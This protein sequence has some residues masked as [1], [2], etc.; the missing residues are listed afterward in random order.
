MAR[1]TKVSK[2]AFN[3]LSCQKQTLQ[4]PTAASVFSAVDVDCTEIMKH[5]LFAMVLVSLT[6]FGQAQPNPGNGNSVVSTYIYPSLTDPALTNFNDQHFVA[7]TTNASAR[8]NKLLLHLPGSGHEPWQATNFILTAA[9]LGYH[10]IS[11][12]YQNVPT[13]ATFCTINSDLDCFRSVT[14]EN[15]TG[16]FW[17]DDDTNATK[18]VTLT[19][20]ITNRVVKLLTFLS[21]NALAADQDWNQFLGPDGIQWSKVA[22]S[23]HSQGGS[24]AL[25]LTKMYAVDRAA[26]FSTV[27]WI[28]VPTN[29]RPTWFAASGATP[30]ER[31]YGFTHFEDFGGDNHEEQP[32]IWQDLGMT[33]FGPI[34]RVENYALPFAGSH[35]LTTLLRPGS[36]K[37]N[38]ELEYHP[39]VIIDRAI[40]TNATGG[41]TWVPVW[42]YMLTNVSAPL[43]AN[44]T[45]TTNSAGGRVLSW[46]GNS[47]FSS[48]FEHSRDLTNWLKLDLP[49]REVN[50]IMSL[51]I[52]PYLLDDE[53]RFFRL[54]RQALVT[55]PIPT[56][57]GFHTDMSFVH[58]GIAR[59]Y[60]LKIPSNWTAATNWPVMIVLPGHGQSITEFASRQAE[61]VG[62]ADSEGFIVVFAEAT[63]GID[64]YK[65]FA[66]D[67]PHLTQ[68]YVDDA[69]FLIA[70]ADQLKASGLNVNSNR[71]YLAGFSNGGSMTHY[72]ASRTNHPFAAF[73][74]MESGTASGTGFREPYDRLN[75]DAGI[76]VAAQVPLP[77]QPRPVLL[78]NMATSVPW[79]FEGRA[80]IRG[81]RENVARWTQANGFGGPVTNGLGII[82]PPSTPF[83]TTSN[84]TVVGTARPRVAY[85]DIRPDHNWPTNLIANGWNANDA[86]RFPYFTTQGTNSV[87]QR[88]PEW[89]RAIYPHSL[90]PDPAAPGKFVRVDSGTM[91]VEIWRTAPMNRTNE[92]IFVGLSDGG[93]QWPNAADKLPFNANVEVLRF[94]EAH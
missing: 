61:L 43:A 59:N 49:A 19:D 80:P 3:L 70:L 94:F 18:Q 29:D 38:G 75:P 52:P 78:M 26:L 48:Q 87:D 64:S 1:C 10:A 91:T 4:H 73:A 27:D 88:L 21:T 74:I 37:E 67:D 11:I 16:A 8:L 22:V 55:S 24:C 45:L 39:A 77:W 53:Q 7:L 28:R 36:T 2:L 90:S 76:N 40:P 42:S 68:P 54:S 79:V 23:G 51:E 85:D 47:G 62:L 32:T 31:L 84:W 69:A 34:L 66:F 71:L 83:N 17:A 57:A 25:M 56:A 89:V 20:S 65:W 41:V 63:A 92:V 12:K 33:A 93:H 86:L 14:E 44:L 15:I 58:G 82:G 60:F 6:T 5:I 46:Q 50:A 35:T 81:A 72:M 9:S 30:P 13:I